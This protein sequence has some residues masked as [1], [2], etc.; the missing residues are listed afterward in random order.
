MRQ[1]VWFDASIVGESAREIRSVAVE[2]TGRDV[3]EVLRAWGLFA[4]G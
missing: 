4:Q 1:R 3:R 2:G